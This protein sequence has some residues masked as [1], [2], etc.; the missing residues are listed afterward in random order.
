MQVEKKSCCCAV[1]QLEAGLCSERWAKQ[2][3]CM[4]MVPEGIALSAPLHLPSAMELLKTSTHSPLAG[5][6]LAC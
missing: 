4:E 2:A 5:N 6:Y 1:V 3:P